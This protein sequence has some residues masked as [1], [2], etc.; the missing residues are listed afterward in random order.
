MFL[1]SASIDSTFNSTHITT[2]GQIEVDISFH[3]VQ[4]W[5]TGPLAV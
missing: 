4:W 3:T 1:N 5:P 2:E